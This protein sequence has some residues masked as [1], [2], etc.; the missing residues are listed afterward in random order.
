LF[1]KLN[2]SLQ[3]TEA[4]IAAGSLL[5]LLLLSLSQIFLRNLFGYGYPEVDIINR[6][7]LVICGMMGA[8]LATSK[9]THIKTDALGAILTDRIKNNLHLPLS[10]FSSG[11]CIA[12][13]YFSITFVSDE[14]QYAPVNERWTLSFT[15][16]YPV[17]FF[18]M[19][20]H[21]VLNEVLRE[22]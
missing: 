18:L 12:L 20:L 21:F 8:V 17:S 3:K 16:I 11:I 4:A 13:C 7:L 19:S 2:H 22:K 5:L 10:L 1:K 6:N 14:W 9:F 15:L